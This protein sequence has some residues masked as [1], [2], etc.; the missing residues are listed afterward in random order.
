[1]RR[2]VAV[3]ERD[4]E[5]GFLV[6]HVPGFPGAHSQSES[7][8]ELRSNLKEVIEMLLGDGEPELDAE[9]G[10]ILEVTL[11]EEVEL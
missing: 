3:V 8:D 9:C 6:G 7:F 2:Y 11:L 5:T 4:P 10:G 1:M